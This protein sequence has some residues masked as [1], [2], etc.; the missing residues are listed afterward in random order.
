MVSDTVDGLM[1]R[2]LSDGQATVGT[3]KYISMNV[4]RPQSMLSA[5]YFQ[6]LVTEIEM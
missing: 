5:R 2:P 3:K 4:A 6:G 1:A